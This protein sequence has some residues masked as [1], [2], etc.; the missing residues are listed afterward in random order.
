MLAGHCLADLVIM[1]RELP[2]F[3][4]TAQLGKLLKEEFVSKE[5]E[6][7]FGEDAPECIDRPYG[8]DFSYIGVIV[9]VAFT[10]RL[11]NFKFVEADKHGMFRRFSLIVMHALSLL[12]PII[13]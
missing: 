11:S 4:A 10:T 2:S 9:R 6:S 13:S 7:A 12:I 1:L 3:S 5:N 8:F